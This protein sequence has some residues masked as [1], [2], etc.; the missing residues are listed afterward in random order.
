MTYF[1]FTITI[2]ILL[3]LLYYFAPVKKEEPEI[4]FVPEEVII[5]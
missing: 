3:I 1:Y 4:K 2:L 5:K